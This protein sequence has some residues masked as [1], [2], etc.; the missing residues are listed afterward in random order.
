MSHRLSIREARLKPEF[1]E[2]YPP[3]DPD[4]WLPAAVASARVLLWQAR[5][6]GAFSLGQ[7]TLDP[8]HFEFRGG[9]ADA[10]SPRH[11]GT[12]FGDHETDWPLRREARLRAEFAGL[13]PAV[14]PQVWMDASEVGAVLLRW[15]AGG[16]EP[17]PPLGPRLL[18]DA[19]F[20]F[21]GGETPRGSIGSPRTRREDSAKGRGLAVG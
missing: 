13:Y 16:G 20:E 11:Q 7:R 1:A 21:R 6:R 19:H 18:H 12:R 5:Q 17:P 3:L 4:E 10:E 2:L 8:R 9:V 15:I 14:P